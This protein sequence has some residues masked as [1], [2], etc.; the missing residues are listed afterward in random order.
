MRSTNKIC[1]CREAEECLQAGNY[2]AAIDIYRRLVA[3]YPAEESWLLA[4]AWA[5]YDAG[6]QDE[7]IVCF[8]QLF[9]QELS[10][11]VFTGFAYDELVRIYK[12]RA[13]YDRLVEVCAKA[14]TAQP[15]DTALLGELGSAYLQAGMTREARA[16]CRKAIALEPEGASLYCLLGETY[17]AAREFASA[18]KA[19][20]RAAKLD[21]AAACSFFSRL[22][23]SYGRRGEHQR[24]EKILRTCLT[25]TPLDPLYHCRMGDCLINQ[26]QLASAAAAYEKA[27]AL[28][29]ASADVFHHRWGNTLADAHYPD[30]AVRV[31]RFKSAPFSE[32]FPS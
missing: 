15:T 27:I 12:T 7:A 2:P 30:E 17:L 14:V 29:P 10:R 25:I 26:G 18:E 32:A 19:Y 11:K 13:Q 28:S 1:R 20:R 5:Y 21:P 9:A 8:E 6:R 16:V 3:D 24:E 4:L 22:A 31:F 23:A